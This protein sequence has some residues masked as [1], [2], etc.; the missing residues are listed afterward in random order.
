MNNDRNLLLLHTQLPLDELWAQMK[1]NY[2]RIANEAVVILIKFSTSYLCGLGFSI[3]ANMKT[4]EETRVLSRLPG[5]TPGLSN[6]YGCG[7]SHS[8]PSCLSSQ[9]LRGPQCRWLDKMGTQMGVHGPYGF[10]IS[11]RGFDSAASGPLRSSVNLPQPTGKDSPGKLFLLL[12]R[13]LRHSAKPR[14]NHL[15][16]KPSLDD[17]H[18]LLPDNDTLST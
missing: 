7:C 1:A 18:P 15:G 16:R 11:E 6:T 12:S 2:P 14:C 13:A 3:L 10:Y 9:L 17:F 8:L 4:H 5:V